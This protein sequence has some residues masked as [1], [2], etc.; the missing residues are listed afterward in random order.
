[1]QL[2]GLENMS[3]ITSPIRGKHLCIDLKP[4]EGRIITCKYCSGEAEIPC[5][6]SL[7]DKLEQAINKANEIL[8]K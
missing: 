6:Q 7:A 8:E 1:M 2:S 3:G 4:A 5:T